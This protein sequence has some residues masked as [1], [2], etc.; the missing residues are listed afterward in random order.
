MLTGTVSHYGRWGS[1][2]GAGRHCGRLWGTVGQ[3]GMLSSTMGAGRHSGRLDQQQ[4]DRNREVA[5][6]QW[7]TDRWLGITALDHIL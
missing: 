3:Y 5:A 2:T 4:A 1:T 6:Q 7:A